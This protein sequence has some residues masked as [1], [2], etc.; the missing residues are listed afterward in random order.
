MQ[1]KLILLNGPPGI[2]KS[3]LSR[4]YADEH[5]PALNIDVDRLRDSVGQW[6]AN[7]EVSMVQRYKFAYAM[8]EIHLNDGYDVAV[9]DTIQDIQVCERFEAIAAGCGA[10]LCE[11]VLIAPLD[12]A[13]ER[14]K[15]RARRMG[16]PSGFRTGG[17][18][19]QGGKEEMLRRIYCEMLDVV[20][21]RPSTV[22]IESREGHIEETYQQ[23]LAVT[24]E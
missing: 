8:A 6:Q 15:A 18:L 10:L 4:R 16:Y 21:S 7:Q 13:I 3:T 2:G 1:P 23:L 17:T 24:E 14:C 9:A 22:K 5:A 20:D 19:E 12:E 11:V